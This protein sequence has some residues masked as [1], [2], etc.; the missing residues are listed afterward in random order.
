LREHPPEIE[1]CIRGVCFPPA[2]TPPGH[3][4]LDAVSHAAELV[5]GQPAVHEGMTAVTDLAW[6]AGG[7]ISGVIFGPG[8]IG[9][10]H[11]DDEWIGIDELAD[12]VFALSIAICEWC[13][14][15]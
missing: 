6:L 3:P 13:G 11:G 7:G 2:E 4:L 1:W 14:V 9:N 8:S 10:A 12:G 15:A 5:T